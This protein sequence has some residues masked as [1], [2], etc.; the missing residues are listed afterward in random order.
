METN[1][2]TQE[3]EIQQYLLILQRRWRLIT[4][5]ILASIGLSG[6]ALFMQKPEYQADGILLFKSDRTSSLTKVGEK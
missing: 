2:Y 1:S 3:A 6:S 5:I 4:A